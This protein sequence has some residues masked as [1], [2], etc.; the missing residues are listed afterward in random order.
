M[1]EV[2][3]WSGKVD[4]DEAELWKGGIAV[5]AQVG[6]RACGL[7]YTDNVSAIELRK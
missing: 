7:H 1:R 5:R 2:H 3:H 4:R 6:L